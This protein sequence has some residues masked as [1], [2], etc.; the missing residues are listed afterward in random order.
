VRLRWSARARRHLAQ[1]EAYIAR[2]S[3]GNARRFVARLTRSPTR[4]E[5]FPEGGRPVPEWEGTACREVPFDEYRIIYR[6]LASEVE[7]IAVLHCKRDLTGIE[8]D[9]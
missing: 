7:I 6:V 2:D 5:V 8:I 3:P 4:L 1:I 9:L